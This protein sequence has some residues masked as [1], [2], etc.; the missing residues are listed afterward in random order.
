MGTSATRA[1]AK[2]NKENYERITLTLS[3]ILAENFKNL[4][5]KNNLSQPKILAKVLEF[6]ESNK[7][8]LDEKDEKIK[9]SSE[10]IIE[11]E[12][13]QKNYE[14]WYN[15]MQNEKTEIQNSELQANNRLLAIQ[16]DTTKTVFIC[17][18]LGFF[19]GYFLA[20]IF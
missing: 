1:K 7:K 8:I 11:L 13:I 10:R 12:N 16:R 4:A 14:N 3:P 18:F 15:S 20:K 2:Y 17:L 19:V 6:Y 5:I 9:K